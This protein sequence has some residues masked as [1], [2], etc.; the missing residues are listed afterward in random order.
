MML[1]EDTP[2]Y[3]LSYKTGWAHASNRHSIGWINGWIEENHHPYFFV[4]LVESPDE[5]F[6]MQAVRL[7]ILKQI[8]AKYGFMQGKK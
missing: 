7:K 5:N 4:L 1:Q 3:K 6:N 2:E 8:L